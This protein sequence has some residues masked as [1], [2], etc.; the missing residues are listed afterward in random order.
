MLGR[1]LCGAL[2]RQDTL[3]RFVKRREKVSI[4][5]IYNL[6]GIHAVIAWDF[7]LHVNNHLSGRKMVIIKIEMGTAGFE[8][9]GFSWAINR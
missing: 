6:H 2:A 5:K 8:W 3:E 4:M 7:S 9:S 1:Q